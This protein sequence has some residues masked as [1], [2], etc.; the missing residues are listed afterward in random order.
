VVSIIYLT[1]PTI[2]TRN[3][4]MFK[5]LKIFILTFCTLA[6][7]SFSTKAQV[8]DS[9]LTGGLNALR[10]AVPFLTI[11]PD[12]RS[13]GMGD[14][15]AA[16][17]PDN[18][19]IH[20]NPAKLAFIDK[21]FGVSYSYTPWLSNLV[22]DINLNYLTGFFRIDNEQVV[23]GSFRYFSM[24]EI[25][26]TNANGDAMSKHNPNELAVDIAY[27]R[28]FADLVSGGI[29][30]RYIRSDLTGR[31]AQQGQTSSKAGTAFAADISLYYEQPLHINNRK[32]EAA[33]GLNISNI[34]SKLSYNDEAIK[35]FIP[36]NLR[37]GGRFSMDI[38]EYNYFSVLFDAN[39][40]LVPTPPIY[41]E[42]TD[43]IAK[44]KDPNV[45]VAQGMLQSFYDAPGGAKEEFK[46]ISYACGVEYWY[47]KQFAIRGGY[48]G[49][50]KTKG[51]RKYFTVGASLK[52]NIFTLDFSYLIPSSGQNN[53]LANT[54]RFTLSFD[55][56]KS[57][58]HNGKK[59]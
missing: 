48:F 19:S 8:G 35:D 37:L 52:Y 1:L 5:A 14:V 51:N 40:L 59:K 16:S 32:A 24:G 15:G 42:G 31:Y 58:K 49:E 22:N 53:P 25:T 45:S 47:A 44:G 38:D 41:Y 26:F 39:K 50:D 57:K 11:A 18:N 23:G 17:T 13:A 2:L 27:S 3:L 55:F 46:E 54:K 56:E 28:K 29:A 6:L 20:W 33:F 7:V 36:I 9:I 4:T 10:V 43:V 12:S 30:F 21:R 34:G